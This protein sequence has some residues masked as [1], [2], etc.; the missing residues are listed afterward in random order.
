M[1]RKL[2]QVLETDA[3][4][5]QEHHQ[6]GDILSLL[7]D[8]IGHIQNMYLRAIFPTV[9]AGTLTLLI[10][11]GLGI[12]DW[13]FALWV[14]LLLL[15]QIVLIPW[16][17]LLIETKRKLRQK[18]LTQKAYVDLT[19]AVLGLSDW[20]IT[21]RQDTFVAQASAATAKLAVSTHH[22]KMFQWARDFVSDLFFGAIPAA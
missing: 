9:V 19:D 22:S 3:A 16:W 7:S 8:D 11:L 4:F 10:T 6:T 1:R 12:F 15:V 17:G 13:R 5:V 18:E 2:Y 20:A 21:H 14:L